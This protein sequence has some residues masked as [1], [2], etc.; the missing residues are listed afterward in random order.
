MIFYIPLENNEKKAGI[1]TQ[2][3]LKKSGMKISPY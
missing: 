2:K 3:A 1:K